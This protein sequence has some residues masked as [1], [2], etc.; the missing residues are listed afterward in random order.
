MDREQGFGLYGLVIRVV[1]MY[2]KTR[3][4]TQTHQHTLTNTPTHTESG[5]IVGF[6]V[7]FRVEFRVW[8]LVYGLGHMLNVPEAAQHPVSF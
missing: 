1:C 2:A 6:R 4:P 5:F 3:T 8:C 7:G